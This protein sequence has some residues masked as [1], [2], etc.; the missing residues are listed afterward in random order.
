[1]ALEGLP[2]DL[3]GNAALVGI[4]NLEGLARA[5]VDLVGQSAP[6]NWRAGLAEDIREDGGLSKF[7][8]TEDLARSYKN[9]EGLVGRKRAMPDENAPDSE[10]D[11]F[12]RD[13]GRPEAPDKYELQPPADFPKEMY[14]PELEQGFRGLAHQA[15]LN[16]KQ[17]AAIYNGFIKMQQEMIAQM[18][19]S[20]ARAKTET[21]QALR[22]E[23]GD[24]Y[25]GRIADANAVIQKVGG[26]DPQV[27]ESLAR[28]DP[29]WSHPALIR[30]LSNIGG[31]MKDS[32][33][34]KGEADRTPALQE[35][36]NRLMSSEAYMTPG[37]KDRSAT[38]AKV[39]ALYAQMKLP[40]IQE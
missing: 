30:F 4:D 11:S 7:K 17:T 1:M 18:V 21:E 9:L 23:W 15:G 22:Q 14:S 2:Q 36:V 5:H 34:Y 13:M 37:H 8:N 28:K 10:W 24:Q 6:D 16:Q 27:A 40:P 26:N 3:A 39:N 19:Q 31:A 20:E 38:V 32:A 33:L 29:V 12:W 25:D 35:E